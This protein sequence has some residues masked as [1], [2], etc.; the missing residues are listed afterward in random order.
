MV[1]PKCLNAL[2]DACEFRA[3]TEGMGAI[4]ARQRG[5]SWNAPELE[6]PITVPNACLMAASVQ[7]G[8]GGARTE[9]AQDTER[10]C[11]R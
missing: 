6:C 7:M 4:W 10:V 8:G 5:R 2:L 3:G 11:G 9:R 1:S